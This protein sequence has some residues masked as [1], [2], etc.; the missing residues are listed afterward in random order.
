MRQSSKSF[1]LRPSAARHRL[2][3]MRPPVVKRQTFPKSGFVAF[4][5]R[6]APGAV[7]LGPVFWLD[8]LRLAQRA[9]GCTTHVWRVY[10]HGDGAC[11]EPSDGFL[12]PRT[13]S[14]PS[15]RPT[16]RQGDTSSC[17]S[18]FPVRVRGST[19]APSGTCAFWS[20]ASPGVQ[21]KAQGRG[22]G[23]MCSGAFG[24]AMGASWPSTVARRAHRD[25]V[26]RQAR[27]LPSLHAGARCRDR[28]PRLVSTY[29]RRLGPAD[30][31]SPF[32]PCPGRVVALGGPAIVGRPDCCEGIIAPLRR[33]PT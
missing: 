2:T 14:V 28:T 30:A 9:C 32:M 6:R 18:S 19:Q 10:R 24:D 29:H 5:P 3:L 11:R 15:C 31:P 33:R 23:P 26:R 22:T 7:I 16:Q 20:G 8:F 4:F 1:A 21:S 25:P 27:L 12:R 13:L 17:A